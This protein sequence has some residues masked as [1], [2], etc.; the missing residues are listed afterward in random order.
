MITS[1]FYLTGYVVKFLEHS[2]ALIKCVKPTEEALKYEY[3][4]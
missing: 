4:F 3:D 1:S 2:S